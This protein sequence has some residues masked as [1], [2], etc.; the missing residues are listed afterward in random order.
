MNQYAISIQETTLLVE[1]GA[2]LSGNDNHVMPP[3]NWGIRNLQIP[4]VVVDGFRMP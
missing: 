1:S 2:A 3:P 4:I